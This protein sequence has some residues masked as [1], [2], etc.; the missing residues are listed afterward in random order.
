MRALLTHGHA[1]LSATAYALA[2]VMWLGMMAIMM[3][4][5][6]WPWLQA[7]HRLD[8]RPRGPLRRT[9]STVS[10]AGG[11]L[12]AWLGYALPAAALQIGL[13]SAGAL[14]V[15]SGLAPAIGAGVLVVAGLFQLTPLKRACL[16]HCR[17]PFSYFLSRW[18]N[19]PPGGFRLG[20]GHGVYCVACCWA[21]M[22][23]ALAVGV[24]NLWWM[25]ALAGAVCAEQVV[26]WGHRL[27]VPLG[28]ALIVAGVWRW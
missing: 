5:A 15:V 22:T 2:T 1:D 20:I 27:R 26:S 16:T 7:F 25:A 14:D 18:R 21:L 24:M 6:L 12:T 3:A 23:T 10:F 8:H 11:Y 17:S 19:G 28:V 9:A 4:P 13:Q